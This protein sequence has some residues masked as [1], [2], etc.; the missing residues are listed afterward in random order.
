MAAVRTLLAAFAL[1]LA[2]CAAAARSDEAPQFHVV[3]TG[4]EWGA[5]LFQP[6]LEAAV[7]RLP[8]VSV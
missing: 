1:A 4:P 3:G 2:P 8:Q 7:E 6:V 5:D